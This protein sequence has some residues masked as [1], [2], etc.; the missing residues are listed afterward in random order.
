V[1]LVNLLPTFCELCDVTP[2]NPVDGASLAADLRAPGRTRETSVFAEY[3]LRNYRAK[4]MLRRGDFKYSFW[5]N[6]IPELYNL[7]TDP[8]EMHNL[9]PLPEYQGKVEEL[10][11]ELFAWYQPPEI[12]LKPG[13]RLPG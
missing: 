10:K 8:K 12:G 7:R 6:D 2:V 4:Y 1:S 13:T 11:K 5:A 9:A 3:N